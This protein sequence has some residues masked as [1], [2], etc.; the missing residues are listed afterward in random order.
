M[1]K[2]PA[3]PSHHLTGSRIRARRLDLGLSQAALAQ[4][5][6]VSPSY[7]NLIEHNRR[8][9]GGRLLNDIARVLAVDAAVLTSG[10]EGM[11]VSALQAAAAMAGHL[12][13]MDRLEEFAGRFPGW[14]GLIAA[15][16]ARIAA[17]EGQVAAM[18]DRLSHDPRLATSLHAVISAATA[19]RASAD[20]LTTG[21]ALDPDWQDRFHRNIL[22]DSV[23]LAESSRALA[24]YLEQA[25]GAGDTALR[26]PMDEVAAVLDGWGW[27][28]PALETPAAGAAEAL[29]AAVP[30]IGAA[31]RALLAGWLRR[32]A[33][34][35]AALPLAPFLQAGAGGAGAD[36]LAL[37]ARFGVALDRV[38]RRIATLP[39]DGR[40]PFA[41]PVGL[42]V[43]DAAGV[44]VTMRPA[45]GLAL[46]RGGEAC[47]L[48]PL[49]RVLGQPGQPVRAEVRLPGER[50]ARFLCYA[51]A[52]A[53]PADA[54][55]APPLVEATMLA[56]PD[57]QA[58]LR[59]AVPVAA[60]PGCRICPRAGCAARREPSII[61]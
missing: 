36:P 44:I 24:G 2:D 6:A 14:A 16:A 60:G 19:I 56:I 12:P 20:I 47:P 53:R 21:G 11:L 42:V 41:G 18:T 52:V 43:C 57:A 23:R 13:E 39:T 15:Q 28:V 1:P 3:N 33:E 59:D 54:W 58:P 5:V 38:L 4:A 25:E 37:A 10:A 61:A 48:W 30:G 32:Y 51:V 34:D 35:A 50:A 17:L 27:H 8:R 40:G 49:Y 26:S 29:A 46:G 9:I 31:A 45:P 7:L 55:D 22:S